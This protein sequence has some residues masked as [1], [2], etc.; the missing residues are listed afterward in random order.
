MADALA[1]QNN[2]MSK[3]SNGVEVAGD[4]PTATGNNPNIYSN[5]SAANPTVTPGSGSM[6]G[7]TISANQYVGNNFPSDGAFTP[8]F[9][10]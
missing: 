2:L 5:L 4:P 9:G 6:A 3:I 7:G 1:A 10:R 8:S